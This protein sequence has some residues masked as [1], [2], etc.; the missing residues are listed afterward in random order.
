MA[1]H[2]F[3]T[4]IFIQAPAEHVWHV[5]LDV[6]RWP[7]WTASISKVIL[8]DQGP[9][10][11]GKRAKVIQPKLQPAVWKF[12][13]IQ[14]NTGFEWITGN[15]MLRMVAQHWIQP[16]SGGVQVTLTVD[17]SGWLGGYVA[18]KYG[19]LTQ[20]YIQ[21]EANGLKTKSESR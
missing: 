16:I 11:V 7:E 21:M 5:M 12:T 9:I 10:A 14:P 2:Q 13:K 17:V 3:K 4:E 1:F 19:K 20:D 8:L 15:F 18:K 6:E